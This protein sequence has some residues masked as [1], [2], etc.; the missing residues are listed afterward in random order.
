MDD[1]AGRCSHNAGMALRPKKPPSAT[2]M[3]EYAELKKASGWYLA[4]WRD[5]R[6]LTLQEVADEVGTSRGNVHDLETGRVRSGGKPPARYNRDWADLMAKALGTTPGHL[7]DTNPFM[8][9]VDALDIFAG[10]DE[11][12][13]T[14]II[15]M[16][17]GLKRNREG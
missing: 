3:V 13:R 17:E 7:I 14:T 12:D 9:D 5:F 8:A 15:R 11:P 2:R 6:N 1:S 4:A 16:V 10:V